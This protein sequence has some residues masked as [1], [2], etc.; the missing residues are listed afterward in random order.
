MHAQ[1]CL[2]FESHSEHQNHIKTY[3][4]SAVE[5]GVPWSNEV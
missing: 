3:N 5:A 4:T 1:K 2:T